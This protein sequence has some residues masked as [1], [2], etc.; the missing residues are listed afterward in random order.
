MDIATYQYKLGRAE[1]LAGSVLSRRPGIT[2]ME[3]IEK[4]WPAPSIE[5]AMLVT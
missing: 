1:T 5:P 4:G 3:E 2:G